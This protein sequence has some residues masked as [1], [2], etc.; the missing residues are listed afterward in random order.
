[1]SSQPAPEPALSEF[2]RLSGVFFEPQKAFADIAARPR[3]WVPM[4]LLIVVS[5]AYTYSV[6]QR[7]GWERVVRQSVATNSRFQQLGAEEQQR[8]IER[9]AKFASGIGYVAAVAGSPLNIAFIAGVLL[10]TS[11]MAGAQ[12]SYRQLL[13]ITSYAFLTSVIFVALGILVV[14][15]KN[16]DDFN[17]QNPLGFNPGA[18]LDP[19][20][21]PKWL[22][23]L[24]GSA[25]L[26][27]FWK[28]ALLAVGIAAGERK[29][30]FG[31]ALAAVAMPWLVLVVVK[32]GWSS[33]FG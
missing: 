12:L 17:V 9:G 32:A 6:A 27:A 23:S 7:V 10:L 26:F 22:A 33:A 20:A 25:D 30:S 2:A 19:S 29:L 28:I 4:I 13:A 21:T 16:P 31:R 24:A 1:M 3:W 8:S 15:L 14:Y 11:R 18:Y 5:L